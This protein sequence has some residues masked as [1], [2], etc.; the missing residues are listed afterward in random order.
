MYGACY[1]VTELSAS[2]SLS[3][4]T[5]MLI[6]W[7]S[8]FRHLFGQDSLLCISLYTLTITHA[9]TFTITHT[10]IHSLSL[11][12][13]MMKSKELKTKNYSHADSL[14]LSF[15]TLSNSVSLFT[16]HTHSL[17]LVLVVMIKSKELKTKI[18]HTHS[19]ILSLFITLHCTWCYD[20]IKATQD[21][22][23]CPSHADILSI[24]YHTP[25]CYPRTQ[26]WRSLTELV[27]AAPAA[28]SAGPA[29]GGSNHSEAIDQVSAHA[30]SV[31]LA[32][33][34]DGVVRWSRW[35]SRGNKQHLQ[36]TLQL[37]T[38]VQL[39]TC[40]C[41]RLS[42]TPM[43]ISQADVRF[44]LDAPRCSRRGSRPNNQ[45]GI[46][47]T[48]FDQPHHRQVSKSYTSYIS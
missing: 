24:L 36:W 41:N 26:L 19:L 7:F 18:S 47:I 48:L 28:S 29:A 9:H 46:R 37:A 4:I 32:G 20:E 3:F 45:T 35:G 38:S 6:L 1:S 40:S 39:S 15:I 2:L 17:S 34:N 5:L 31:L 14:I 12:L 27:A 42:V 13:V 8:L 11:V 10:H 30:F 16:T 22:K 25:L 23:I 44:A 33:R 21:S 43:D